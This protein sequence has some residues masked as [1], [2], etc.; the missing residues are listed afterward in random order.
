MLSVIVPVYNTGR[1]LGRCIDSLNRQKYSN[2]EIILI[3][4]GSTD[5][6]PRLCDVYAQGH[7]NIRV[8]HKENGGLGY[9]RNSGLDMARG[10][11][12][13]F[14][15]SDDYVHEDMYSCMMA[16]IME[17]NAEAAFCDFCFVRS[18]GRKE[19]ARSGISAG[20][21]PAR[22]ILLGMLG[23]SPEARGDFDFDM[24]VCKAVYS[25]NVIN[26]A[27]IRFLSERKVLCEDLFFNLEF[28]CRA[29]AAVYVDTGLYYYC[30]N[31]GSLTH[32]Y[33]ED[34]L[35]KEKSMFQ[36]LCQ[37][38]ADFLQSDDMLRLHKLFLSRIRSTITQ[39]VYYKENHSFFERMRAISQIASDELVQA[40][41]KGYPIARNPLKLRVFNTF[42][43]WRFSLGMYIL[44]VLNR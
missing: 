20:K 17:E 16:R 19:S 34:R 27:S 15:D 3:D 42:L 26:A 2:I 8:L 43:K 29:E 35:S 37:L 30:E 31:A 22:D 39:Y 32:R 23:A 9:A 40:V 28:L 5:D 38:A 24:S 11:Y 33:I 41:V 13:A 7:E 10:A 1:F 12:V 36:A 25:L 4:D 18:D 44:I 21:H 14:L 6:S